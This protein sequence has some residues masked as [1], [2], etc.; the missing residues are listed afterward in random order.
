[1]SRRIALLLEYDGARYAGSQLQANAATVQ[2]VLEEAIARTTSEAARVA[3][4][5]RTDAGVHAH[6]QVACFLTESALDA[7]T[8]VAALNAWLPP[9]VAVQAAADVALDFDVRRHARRRRYRY[10]I[11]NRRA[12]PALDRER[13]WHV[14][15]PL[16]IAAM[17]EAAQRLLGERD[18]AAF[19]SPQ[20]RPGASTLRRLEAFDVEGTAGGQ[21]GCDLVANAF[22]PRQVR[23]MI[24]ALVEV[25]RGRLSADDYEGLLAGPPASSGPAA[26]AHAL[27]LVEVEYAEP[28]FEAALNLASRAA[29]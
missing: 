27:Y 21:I 5:G 28:L 6:G 11:D 24:G 4:A 26:P 14:A 7:P 19:A 20:E 10:L 18:F 2:S 16:D 1:L 13:A 22:L 25:G 15:Q 23:R 3:M 9:D 29:L 12:R 17:A 8:L